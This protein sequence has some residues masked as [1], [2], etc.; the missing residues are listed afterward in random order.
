MKYWSCE[1]CTFFHKSQ[2]QSLFLA[3][4]LCGHKRKLIGTP[5]DEIKQFIPNKRSKIVDVD[6]TLDCKSET[7][8]QEVFS[9]LKNEVSARCLVKEISKG[10]WDEKDISSVEE[11]FPLMLFENV[12]ALKDADLVLEKLF[13]RSKSWDSSTWHING[14][15]RNTQVKHK[16]YV[17]PAGIQLSEF[18]ESEEVFDEIKVVSD[19]IC[20]KISKRIGEDWKPTFSFVN[21]YENEK[22]VLGLHSDRLT[23]VGPR[24]VIVSYTLGASRRFDFISKD[25]RKPSLQVFLPHN[26]ALVMFKNAQEDFKHGIPLASFGSKTNYLSSHKLSGTMRISLTLRKERK[27]LGDVPLCHCKEKSAMKYINGQYAFLCQQMN[28]AKVCR[29]FQNC[30]WADKI[31]NELTK[32]GL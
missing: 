17:F 25:S 20:K 30:K 8:R 31:A 12:C 9:K 32:K 23:R 27:D 1:K 16:V 10:T 28:K 18:K 24:P 4:A 3:C 6:L 13:E 7:N 22:Q 19:Q 14:K 29:F 2:Q 26:S 11:R 5:V 21:C 15:E